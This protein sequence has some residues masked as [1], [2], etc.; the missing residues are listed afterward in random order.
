MSNPDGDLDIC[1]SSINDVTRAIVLI[2]V[3]EFV[4]NY[5]VYYEIF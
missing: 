2:F 3:L 4:L 1:A 5:Y